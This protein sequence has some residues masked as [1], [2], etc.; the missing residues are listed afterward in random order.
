MMEFTI[1]QE[2]QHAYTKESLWILRVG[3]EQIL[4]RTKDLREIWFYP[5]ELEE[6]K[7]IRETTRTQRFL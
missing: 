4:C 3:R 5:H 1:G 6:I 2:V 7:G